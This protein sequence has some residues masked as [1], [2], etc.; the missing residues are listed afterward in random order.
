MMV[1]WALYESLKRAGI[2][3][4]RGNVVDD[5]AGGTVS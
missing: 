3:D 1:A 5:G 2:L 4:D